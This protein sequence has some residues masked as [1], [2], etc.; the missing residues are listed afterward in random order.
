M[1]I[2]V[3]KH[4]HI[5]TENDF[6]IGRG[7]PLGNPYTSIQG[8]QTKA[9]FIC[10]TREESISNFYNYII[11]KILI[12]DVL[13][14]NELNKIWKAVK[15]GKTVNLV[16]YCVP[17]SCHGNI[18]KNII[19]SKINKH[20]TYKGEI[21]ILEKNQIAVVGTNTQGR[22][23]KGFALICNQK[24]GLPYGIARGLHGQSYGIVTKDLTKK[25]HPSRTPDQIKEEIKGLYECARLNPHLNFKVPYNCSSANL[26]FYS[27]QEMADFFKS[28]EIPLNI[29]FEE[30]FYKLIVKV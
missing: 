24:Y 29:E 28:F 8:K 12:K 23:G 15:A 16:C 1:I 27:A 13:I 6:Y 2:V 18:I 3:N 25:I 26:N 7:S 22:H 4:T 21:L 14:C 9:Q 11:E 30:E 17:K 20:K 19:E 10:N 5:P